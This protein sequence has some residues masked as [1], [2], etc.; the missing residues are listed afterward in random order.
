MAVLVAVL[1]CWLMVSMAV[2]MVVVGF[3]GFALMGARVLLGDQ[4]GG[5]PFPAAFQKPNRK[6][7]M[8]VKSSKKQDFLT[9]AGFHS[10]F[11]FVGAWKS[12]ILVRNMQRC[13]VCY[14]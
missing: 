2:F 7:Q 6:P 13:L 14:L 3:H 8:L 10:Y 12:R 9:M 4:G 1:F 5:F 11:C